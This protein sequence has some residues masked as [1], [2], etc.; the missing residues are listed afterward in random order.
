MFNILIFLGL[1]VFT[2]QYVSNDIPTKN[3]VKLNGVKND[4]TLKSDIRKIID[5]ELDTIIE[6]EM[7]KFEDKKKEGRPL[8][9]LTEDNEDEEHD[10][11]KK[12][13]LWWRGAVR[14]VVRIVVP[15]PPPKCDMGPSKA[16][17]PHVQY[18]GCGTGPLAGV[19]TSFFYKN[20]FTKACYK[21]DVCFYCGHMK[22]WSQKQCDDRFY[23]DM[24]K[25]CNCRYPIGLARI[26]CHGAARLYWTGPRTVGH[27]LWTTD[28]HWYCNLPCANDF[29]VHRS[30][31]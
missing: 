8:E 29:S 17:C 4:E 24:I 3:G 26:N 15:P 20:L 13:P 11:A 28:Y 9:L 25:I 12:D 31:F 19:Q 18:N 27:T 30:V 5:E 2:H 22:K 7:E 1:F 10:E 6:E 21:H 14:H 16:T 23:H